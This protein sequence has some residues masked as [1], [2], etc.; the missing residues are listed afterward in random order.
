MRGGPEKEKESDKLH[1]PGKR[2]KDE[3]RFAHVGEF[4]D[5]VLS[6]TLAVSRNNCDQDVRIPGN[7]GI[8]KKTGATSMLLPVG[9]M[10]YYG[11]T[12][13]IGDDFSKSIAPLRAAARY[14]GITGTEAKIAED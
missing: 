4:T 1:T 8:P 5:G 11:N 10:D 3:I 12:I 2:D 14:Y 6:P 13:A 7:I 9:C